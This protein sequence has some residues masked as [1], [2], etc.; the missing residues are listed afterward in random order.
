[1]TQPIKILFVLLAAAA[2][3]AAAWVALANSGGHEYGTDDPAAEERAVD[4][5]AELDP[6]NELA[7]P[8]GQES[9]RVAAEKDKGAPSASVAPSKPTLALSVQGRVIDRAGAPVPDATVLAHL[10]RSVPGR[11]A[12]NWWSIKFRL[13]PAGKP[14]T[15]AKDG[16]FSFEVEAFARSRIEVAATHERFAPSLVAK[17][18]TTAQG[19]LKLDDLVLDTG[20]LV[21]GR[22]L[23]D[24]GAPL[25]G[26]MILYRTHDW[27]RNARFNNLLAP[28]HT[29]EHGNFEQRHVPPGRFVFEA[30]FT[31]YIPA[32]SE[33]LV[34][35]HGNRLDAGTITLALGCGV[36]GRLL[37]LE[38]NPIANATVTGSVSRSA[39]GD[40]LKSRFQDLKTLSKATRSTAAQSEERRALMRTFRANRKI[41]RSAKSD[42]QGHFSLDGL[43]NAAL[44]L[45]AQHEQFIDETL[46]PVLATP[47]ATQTVEI[48]MHRRLTANGTVVN[49][50]S[51]MPVERFGIRARRIGRT[52]TRNAQQ[53]AIAQAKAVERRIVRERLMQKKNL[54]RAAKL[55]KAKAKM[56]ASQRKKLDAELQ[57]REQR[58]A[59][60]QAR[61][62]Q[63][64]ANRNVAS[65]NRN[66][67]RQTRAAY[68]QQRLGPTGRPAG[69][70]PAPSKHPSGMFSLA[71]LVP[72]KYVFDVGGPGYTKQAAGPFMLER[73][74]SVPPVT[75]HLEPGIDLAGE[76]V[77]RSD[78]SP[79]TNAS[80]EL[81]IPPFKLAPKL[82]DPLMQAI[83][84]QSPGMRIESVKTDGKGRFRLAPQRAGLFNLIVKAE[85]FSTWRKDGFNVGPAQHM[86]GL[87][88][89]L[90]AGGRVWGKVLNLE[91]DDEVQVV[92]ASTK[93]T[94]RFIDVDKGAATFE[95]RGLEPGNWFVRLHHKRR[96]GGML[97]KAAEAFFQPGASTPDIVLTEGSDVQF[98]IDATQEQLGTIE[99]TV[100]WNNKPGQGFEVSLVPEP[101]T[102]PDSAL[103]D[104]RGKNFARRLLS[105]ILRKNTNREG[106]FKIEVVPPGRYTLKVKRSARSNRNKSSRN[107]SITHQQ[108]VI[109][110]K[111]RPVRLHIAVYTGNLQLTAVHKVT[112]KPVR[113]RVMLADPVEAAGKEPK[114]W[115]NLPSHVR[116]DLRGGRAM[117]RDM[118]AGEYV[119]YSYGSGMKGASGRLFVSSGTTNKHTFEAEPRAKSTGGR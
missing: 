16:T 56:N 62:A 92:L 116:A 17:D 41:R 49:S 25:A 113:L 60:S 14:T 44:S 21:R 47:G 103:A 29:D 28:V 86:Q 39:E 51:G 99:G 18:W 20:A 30:R 10:G 97:R 105:G 79:I 77:S 15:T 40:K 22:V 4:N 98:N 95:A 100:T 102:I 76:V 42:T 36:A 65:T 70:V 27:P 115:G 68:L 46:Q 52:P 11:Q 24:R 6:A 54:D 108:H 59:R 57:Q 107:R 64:K 118:K 23:S 71:N 32:Q 91:K 33:R 109:I 1:M 81:F 48:R 53:A 88:F 87:R 90:G 67:A 111:D 45:L 74:Q 37:D 61:R 89:T 82:S 26:A 110:T 9:E 73:G 104:P 80:V 94:R 7:R 38:G 31:K 66:I 8:E 50:V 63:R 84:P 69:R 85:G 112:K 117:L 12:R 34:S 13:R 101:G 5:P 58:N 119:W 72:G 75:I 78:G 55:A 3:A 2:L 35:K 93:G 96:P 83:Q 19:T 43:P 106:K 114:A